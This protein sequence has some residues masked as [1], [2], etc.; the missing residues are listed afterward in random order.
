MATK[1]VADNLITEDPNLANPR[2]LPPTVANPTARAPRMP[3]LWPQLSPVTAA[4][5]APVTSGKVDA[6]AQFFAALSSMGIPHCRLQQVNSSTSLAPAVKAE[7]LSCEKRVVQSDEAKTK[8]VLN[9]AGSGTGSLGDCR[10]PPNGRFS[11]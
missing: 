8:V 2:L 5:P 7:P 1:H 11:S 10:D 4:Q 6:I 9:T 3:A